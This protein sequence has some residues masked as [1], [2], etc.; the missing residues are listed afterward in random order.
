MHDAPIK[1]KW[2][3]WLRASFRFVKHLPSSPRATL[4]LLGGVEGA[5]PLMVGAIALVVGAG[6]FIVGSLAFVVGALAFVVGALAFVVGALAFVVGALAF[7][8]GALALVVVLV[9]GPVA[10][11]LVVVVTLTCF[12]F[13]AVVVVVPASLVAGVFVGVGYREVGAA[14]A[15]PGKLWFGWQDGNASGVLALRWRHAHPGGF[16]YLFHPK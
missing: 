12:G 1:Y 3:A 16:Q 9:V 6:A 14:L 8:V 5:L 2:S 11:A 15:S 13:V 7:V 10:L 4:F